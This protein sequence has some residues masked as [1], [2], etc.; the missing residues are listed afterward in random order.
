[1][2]NHV[3]KAVRA[4]RYTDR[5]VARRLGLSQTAMSD[6]MRGRTRWTLSEAV[7]IARVLQIPVDDLVTWDTP[8]DLVPMDVVSA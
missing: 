5:E 8:Q 4:S 3:A 2:P 6:R 1:M 7:E